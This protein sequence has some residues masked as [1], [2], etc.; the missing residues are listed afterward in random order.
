WTDGG[1]SGITATTYTLNGSDVGK[2]LTF[3][4]TP[5]NGKAVQGT[6]VSISTRDAAGTGG[7]GSGTN[8]GEVIDPVAIP[9]AKDLN[10]SGLLEV[11]Q[12]LTGSYTFSPNG[13]D[14]TNRS[15]VKWDGQGSPSTAMTYAIVA[16]DTGNILTFTVT[17]KN[18]KDVTGTPVSV[19][20]KDAA[21]VSGGGGNNPGEIINP[22]AVPLAENLDIAG[23]L[24]VGQALTGSY[25]FNPNGGDTTDTST[26][27]WSDGG[28]SGVT[29]KT[30][31]LNGSDVGKIL[32]FTVTPK[33]GKNVTGTP[34]SVN[35][36]DATGTTGGD[37]GNKGEVIDPTAKPVVTADDIT[38]K[39]EVGQTLTGHYTFTP[40][41]GDSRDVSTFLWRDGG[42]NGVS[43]KTYSLNASDIGKVL[44]FS[45]TAVNGAGV[46]GNTD[47]ISTKD[48]AGTGG[49][50]GENPGEVIDPAARPS[51]D[52]LNIT[53][54]L[55][56]GQ[57]LTGSY[58]F[59]PNGGDTTDKSTF[60]WDGAGTP[61]NQTAY[62]IV[63]GDVGHILTF[64]VT[65]VNGKAV[66]GTPVS[67]NTRD[68]TGTTG[69]DGNN[70]GEII[71]PGAVPLAENLDI[72]GKLEVGQTLTGSYTFKPNG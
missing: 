61:V 12:T 62:G 43:A 70:P 14:T 1:Q 53:G 27:L 29:T 22:G 56:V 15:T 19:N 26:V 31:S 50:S 5:V 33:N 39:L 57:T 6:P 25:T 40:N 4:V 64:T 24:E 71:N 36:R 59:K 49:G 63:A 16:A 34:V 9:A 55:E 60:N 41:G 54:K 44:T 47:S 48:A 2:I 38:G 11:G 42:Q 37:G 45:V 23:T 52:N 72:A 3:T 46:T 66:T 51:A 17:P 58:T 35:T 18:G 68:A 28:Q 32:T 8:P 7:S 21:G 69:G 10:I 67:V 65:P 20:T 30:Y 13:G